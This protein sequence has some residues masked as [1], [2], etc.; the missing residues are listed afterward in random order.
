MDSHYIRIKHWEKLYENSRS[1]RIERLTWVPIPNKHDGLGLARIM[2]EKDGFE[3]F[4]CWILLLQVASKCKP[5]GSLIDDEGYP[6]DSFSI[7][8][9][10]G[11]AKNK[12]KVMERAISFILQLRWIERVIC[13]TDP[14]LSLECDSSAP[15]L[16]RIEG[17]RIEENKKKGAKRP[18]LD[19]WLAYADERNYPRDDAESAFDHYTAN[20]W[21]QSK[22]NSIKCWK[23][24]LR[25][26]KGFYLK[27]N[28]Q[29]NTNDD[30]SMLRF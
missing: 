2:N 21:K 3:I 12:Q 11:A 19:E 20:G 29:S 25:T 7:I 27:R 6:L 23:A 14:E 5:R 1:R 13:K 24:A 8:I 9:K 16:N 30:P 10:V 18:T 28:P 17:N 22:G 26:C 15:E 4:A